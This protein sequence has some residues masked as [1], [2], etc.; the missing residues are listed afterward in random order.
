MRTISWPGA[1]YRALDD[2]LRWCPQGSFGA[3]CEPFFGSGA[4]TLA[5]ADRIEGPVFVAEANDPLRNWWRWA[6]ADVDSLVVRIA[7]Y[8]DMWS[9]AA[10]HRAEFDT[11]RQ[12]W[13]EMARAE[14]V[15]MDTAALLWCLIYASTNNLARFNRRG[16][17]NQTWGQG[18]AI[19]DPQQ[20]ITPDARRRIQSM[21][22]TTKLFD[23]FSAAL[24][25][26]LDFLDEG[27]TGVC[28]LD[29]PYV[30]EAGMYDAN[31]WGVGQLTR[32]MDFIEGL[33]ARA[34]W[35]LYT[36]Y[37]AKGDAA[38]PYAHALTRFQQVALRT[39]RDARPTGASRRSSEVLT[40]GTVVEARTHRLFEEV[41]K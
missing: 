30:L 41:V 18:R 3:M 27:G 22:P 36:D 9:G 40:V 15:T 19:P 16:G 17:Y 23:D 2:L 11:M 35:W 33:E 26:F 7:E 24:L 21:A 5:L 4:L 34:A 25:A 38:H 31:A 12:T 6:L 39:T 10:T 29:P 1:K 13:N 8:R 32:L 20:V 28:Y 37:M 14:P